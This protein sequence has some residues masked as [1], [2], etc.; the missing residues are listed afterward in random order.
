MNHKPSLLQSLVHIL[1]KFFVEFFFNQKLPEFKERRC[2][3]NLLRVEVNPA[4]FPEGVA[5]VHRI[6]RA[7]VFRLRP[8][9]SISV[10]VNWFMLLLYHRIC[11]CGEL[12]SGSLVT[13]KGGKRLPKGI[14]L[15]STKNS[16]PYIRIRDLGKSKYLHPT[17][18]TYTPSSR[19]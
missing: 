14:N 5:V 11:F 15:I 12:I 13:V 16:H 2:V 7:L 10:N 1:E 3:G 17:G 19:R 9:Y 6:F 8:A 18:T 4:E